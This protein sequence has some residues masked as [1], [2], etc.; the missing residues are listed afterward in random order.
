MLAAAF[1][2]RADH[3]NWLMGLGGVV[4]IIWGVLLYIWPIEGALVLT[5]WVG[6]YALI[7]GIA[8]IALSLRL[9]ARHMNP[10]M[11]PPGA[12]A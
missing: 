6:A 3:G 8:M 1:R 12:P 10:P 4:S 2:L 11:Q 7:F 5:I 9:R